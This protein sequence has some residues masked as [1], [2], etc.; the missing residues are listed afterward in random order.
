MVDFPF[1]KPNLV[2]YAGHSVA[3]G[4]LTMLTFFDKSVDKIS[5]LRAGNQKA[6]E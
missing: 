1:V 2:F 4:V 3:V 6:D 5:G